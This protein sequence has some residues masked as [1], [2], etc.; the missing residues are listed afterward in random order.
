MY[1]IYINVYRSTLIWNDIWYG[2]IYV[3]FE[4]SPWSEV[5]PIQI[6]TETGPVTDALNG[7]S[8]AG[9]GKQ[10]ISTET[11]MYFPTLKPPHTPKKCMK[12]QETL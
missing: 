7:C 12:K 9:M 4:S 6:R 8:H 1:I 3:D 2:K 5:G 10:W 11:N